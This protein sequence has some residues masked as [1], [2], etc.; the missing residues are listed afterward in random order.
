[1]EQ[2]RRLSK[3]RAV[4]YVSSGQVQMVMRGNDMGLYSLKPMA[5]TGSASAENEHV[6][7]FLES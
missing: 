2:K 3:S 1:M 6:N 4:I 7:Y 5:P